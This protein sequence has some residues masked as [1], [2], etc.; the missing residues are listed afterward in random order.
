MTRRKFI[1]ALTSLA[2]GTQLA[3]LFPLKSLI[4]SPSKDGIVM[5]DGWILKEAD[6]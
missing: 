2:A 1:L 5:R 3:S 4:A 6:L